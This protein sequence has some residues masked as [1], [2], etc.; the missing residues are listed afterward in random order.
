MQFALNRL[1]QDNRSFEILHMNFI[2]SPRMD[3]ELQVMRLSFEVL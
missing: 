3:E 2:T 1:Y